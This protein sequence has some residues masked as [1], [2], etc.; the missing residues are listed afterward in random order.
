VDSDGH[1]MAGL[2]RPDDVQTP[3]ATHTGWNHRAAGFRQGDLCGLTGMYVPFA[4]TRAERLAS[5]DP[6][7]S[8]E[9]RY[10]HHGAYVRAVARAAARL[11]RERLLLEEDKERIVE[12]AAESGVGKS[13]H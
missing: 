13:D 4:Q 2:R 5:G 6:R 7:P 8:I 3:L 10:R 12:A 11:V 9:E 1:D